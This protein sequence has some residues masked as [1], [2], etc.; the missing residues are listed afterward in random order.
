MGEEG[1]NLDL[2][3]RRA[4][5]VREYLVETHGISSERLLVRAYG[6]SDPLERDTTPEARTLNRRVEFSLGR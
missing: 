3:Q 1:Y 4:E 5:Q 2:S 6:E